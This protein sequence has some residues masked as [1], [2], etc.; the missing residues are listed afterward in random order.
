MDSATREH[1]EG[2]P[3]ST[4]EALE[5]LIRVEFTATYGSMGF[6]TLSSREKPFLA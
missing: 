1:T 6:K 2:R 5:T 4:A 3:A